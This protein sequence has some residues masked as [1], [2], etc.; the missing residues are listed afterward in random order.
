MTVARTNIYQALKTAL[1]RFLP[2]CFLL[3]LKKSH[4]ARVLGKSSIDDE[5]DLK[6]VKALVVEGDVVVD[7]GANIGLYSYYLSSFVGAGGVVYS[8]EPVPSTFAILSANMSA[9]NLKN[10]Q[11]LPYALDQEPGQRGMAAP[12]FDSGGVNYYRASFSE[13]NGSDQI[14]VSTSSMDSLFLESEVTFV[15]IDVEGAELSVLLGA[16]TFLSQKTPA[17]LIEI[18]G[19]PDDL[20]GTAWKVFSLMKDS[21][22]QTYWFNGEVLKKRKSGEISINYFFLKEQHLEQIKKSSSVVVKDE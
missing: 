15:K 12:K 14:V 21:Q 20:S 2:E 4:Y 5:P 6:V 13:A 10:V 16:Q 17:W 11:L 19:N 18:S 3:P 1:L 22:Y 9:F 8:I 7:V